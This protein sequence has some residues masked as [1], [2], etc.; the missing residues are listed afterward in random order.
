MGFEGGNL[1]HSGDPVV[2]GVR[3]CVVA[4]CYIDSAETEEV[5]KNDDTAETAPFSFCFQLS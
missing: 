4:F 3:Y 1:K 2:D 5:E